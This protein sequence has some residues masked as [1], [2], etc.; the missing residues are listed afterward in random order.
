MEI[1]VWASA[2]GE[3]AQPGPMSPRLPELTMSPPGQQDDCRAPSACRPAE[4][5]LFFPLLAAAACAPQI[6]AAKTISARRQVRGQCLSFA[7][8]TGQAHRIWDGLTKEER[9]TPRGQ[10]VTPVTAGPAGVQIIA[11]GTDVV[12]MTESPG[13]AP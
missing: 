11:S 13:E 8:S 6:A 10:H 12:V 4:P 5:A 7:V 2:S 9:K 3:G 1:P